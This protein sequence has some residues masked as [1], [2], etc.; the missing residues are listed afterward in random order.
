MLTRSVAAIVVATLF[1]CGSPQSSPEEASLEIHSEDPSEAR[2]PLLVEV[3][4]DWGID[5]NHSSGASGDLVFPEMMGGGVAVLDANEDGRLDLYFINGAEQLGQSDSD[6]GPSNQL[7]LRQPDGSYRNT[8]DSSG[9]DDRGY[10]TGVAVGDVDNDGHQDVFVANIGPDHLYRGRGDGTF[11]DVSATSG[12]SATG[13]NHD[14]WSTSAAFCDFNR[15]GYLDLYVVRYVVFDPNVQCTDTAGRREYCGPDGFEDRTDVLLENRGDGTFRNVTDR[16]GI[17]VVTGAGL[18]VVCED[19]NDDG[20]VDIY[21]ANDGDPNQLWINQVDGKFIDDGLIMGASVNAAGLHEAGMGVVAA[22]FDGDTHL[23]LFVTHLRDETNTFYRNLGAGMGFED[24][25]TKV[26]LAAASTPFTGFGVAP[27]DLDLDGDLDIAVANGRVTRG[28]SLTD[29][30]PEPWN[31][32]AEP[33]LVY[34]NSN[35]SFRLLDDNQGVAAF[36]AAAE[37]SRGLAVGDLDGDGGQDLIVSGIESPARVLR[38]TP[39]EGHWLILDAVDPTLGRRAL[40]ARVTVTSTIGR[41][42]RTIQGAM[43]Y[44]SSSDPRAHFGLGDHSEDVSVLVRWP[45]GLE[46]SFSGISVDQVTTLV[47]GEGG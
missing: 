14:D 12:V 9:L 22:D 45:D 36:T 33:N 31:Q 16:A 17:D 23:D 18:G 1:G 47:R 7:F 6:N 8:T 4:T 13:T 27:I 21:V 29:V 46:E 10:G 37:V 35:G 5:F 44:L 34:L 26:G 39:G 38:G 32:Y 24:Q 20:W 30:L 19:F 43:S 42:Q 25:T 3:T 40:G 41:Q 11:A 15:D 2:S 28:E